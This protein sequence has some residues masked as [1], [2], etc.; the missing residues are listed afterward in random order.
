MSYERILLIR[1]Q[2]S[3]IYYAPRRPPVGIG[4]LAEALRKNNITYMII[5]REL[6]GYTIEDIDR[7]IRDFKPDLVGISM[8]TLGYLETYAMIDHI[9]NDFGVDTII[10]GPHVSAFGKEILVDCPALDFAIQSEGEEALVELI[11][12]K[13]SAEIKGLYYRNK[14]EVEFTGKRPAVSDIDSLSWPTYTGFEMERYLSNEM[15]ILTSRG[16][17]YACTFC[18]VHTIMGAKIRLRSVQSV[19]DEMEYW[20]KK[21]Y[22]TFLI[23]DDNFTFNK[24][25]VFDI[26]DDIERRG[27]KDI[28]ISLANGVRADKVDEPML[29]RLKQVGAWEIQIAVESANDRVLKILRKGETLDTIRKAIDISCRLDYDVGLNFLIG[30]PGETWDEVQESFKFVKDYPLQLVF[31]FNIIPYPGTHLF[32]YLSENN[33]MRDDPK[34]YLGTLREGVPRPVFETPELSIEQRLKLLKQ[35]RRVSE[36]VRRAYLKRRLSRF[37]LLAW[38]LAFIGS[39]TVT[40]WLLK[41]NK[42]VSKYLL[43]IYYRMR[44]Y[45]DPQNE[46]I[47]QHDL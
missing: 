45:E 43:P 29:R 13:S 38:P 34:E 12:G 33:L 24:Q 6:G 31:Y 36:N 23:M 8:V 7:K 20:Y 16:C 42:F 30:S 22:K 47:Q 17:P 44:K 28:R 41:R 10:G 2:T 14:G 25:R 46:V 1:Q 39:W 35:A 37:G 15:G 5:D 4:Y 11:Q 27:M 18:S 19:V 40:A 9:K 21:N 3:G 26:C 32:D